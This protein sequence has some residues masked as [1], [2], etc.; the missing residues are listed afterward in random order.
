MSLGSLAPLSP[1]TMTGSTEH[2]TDR[3]RTNP[4]HQQWYVAQVQPRKEAWAVEHLQR[5]GFRTF[6]PRFYKQQVRRSQFIRTL[7]PVFPGY[8][9]VAFDLDRHPWTAIRS[10]RGVTRLVGASVGA[11]QAVQS[12]TM[13]LLFQRCRDEIMIDQF[14]GLKPGDQVLINAGPLA[15]RIAEVHSL[16]SES[17]VALLFDM[18]GFSNLVEMDIAAL[19]PAV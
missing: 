10:T 11:P 6:F 13:A 14:G 7:V 1:Q 16:P 19:S 8:I 2:I 15:Q 4:L 12:A 18:L 17:R 5:Q 3:K 9:F